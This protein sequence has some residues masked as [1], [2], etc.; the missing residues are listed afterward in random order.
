MQNYPTNLSDSEWQV[1]QK[2]QK[3]TR[4]RSYDLRDIW[5]AIFHVDKTGCQRRMLPLYFAP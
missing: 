2:I 4:K 3:D 1:I 5:N